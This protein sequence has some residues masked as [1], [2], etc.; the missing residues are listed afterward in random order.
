MSLKVE[1]IKEFVDKHTGEL[2]TIGSS[3]S[4]D[5]K[6][7]KEIKEA[8]NYVKVIPENPKTSK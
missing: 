5:E 1:T 6:R 2:H 4:C 3:F 8:G 7:L